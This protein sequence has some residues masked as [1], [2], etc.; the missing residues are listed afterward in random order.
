MDLLGPL[1]R[2]AA[3]NDHLSVIVD[4][5]SKMPRAIPLAWIN[6]ETSAAAFLD[7]WVAA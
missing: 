1:P 2:T 4:R 7:Y 3:G 6:A 5:F